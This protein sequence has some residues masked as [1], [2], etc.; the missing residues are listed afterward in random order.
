MSYIGSQQGLAA[1]K[2]LDAISVVNGQAAYSLTKNSVAYKPASSLSL[3]VSLNGII[4]AP[5]S[6]YTISGSTITF[7]SGLVTGDVIDYILDREPTTGTMVPADGSVTT[8]KIG[9][10]A[11][12]DAKI[13]TVAAS[14]L[15]GALPAIDGSA[16]TGIS[17]ASYAKLAEVQPTGVNGGTATSGSWVHRT[18][19]T[20]VYDPDGIVSLSG[21]Q[22]TLGAGTYIVSWS[23]T[24]QA[25]DRGQSRLWNVTDSTDVYYGASHYANS[26]AGVEGAS[27][28]SYRF[29]I[30]SSKTYRIEHQVQTTKAAN[31]WGVYS[32]YGPNEFTIV[33]IVKIG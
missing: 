23:A 25:V 16:L 8:A 15:T 27:T 32:N 28:G 4:Q 6:S 2:L 33:E 5:E 11:V 12:T 14:K 18:L 19:N 29:T 3:Q 26:G 31:G 30:T 10:G 20:E 21:S 1:P 22:F 9:S 7:A 17:S 24:H 13:D